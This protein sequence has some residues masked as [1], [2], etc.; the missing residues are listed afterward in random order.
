MFDGCMPSCKVFRHVGHVRLVSRYWRGRKASMLSGTRRNRGL[1]R[2][3]LRR[4]NASRLSRLIGLLRIIS[5]WL[6]HIRSLGR[7]SLLRLGACLLLLLQLLQLLQLLLLL[8]LHICLLFCAICPGWNRRHRSVIRK[9]FIRASAYVSHAR[10]SSA[11]GGVL[12]VVHHASGLE[13]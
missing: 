7:I 1:S 3:R 6:R 9:A 2:R 11:S 10:S 13:C 4:R 8:L 5:A 12:T